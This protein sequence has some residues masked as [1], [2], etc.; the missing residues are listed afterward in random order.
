MRPTV[1]AAHDIDASVQQQLFAYREV[2][3]RKAIILSIE[4]VRNGI[5]QTDGVFLWRLQNWK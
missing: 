4:L 5:I 3:P 1:P 2:K